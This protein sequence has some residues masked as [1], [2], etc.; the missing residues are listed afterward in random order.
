MIGTVTM[1][2]AAAISPNGTS[3]SPGKSAI[4]TGIVREASVVVKVRAKRNSFQEKM[5]T[6]M[7]AA[8]KCPH[9]VP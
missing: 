9:S 4:P 5:K 7:A 1:R 8:A 6:R 3:W 2:D